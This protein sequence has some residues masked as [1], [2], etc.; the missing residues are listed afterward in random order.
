MPDVT[1]IPLAIEAS[2]PQAAERLL[3]RVYE[4]LRRLAA[5]KLAQ[6]QPGHTLQPTALVHEAYLR[7]MG[8]AAF[9]NHGHAVR[10][11]GRRESRDAGEAPRH[12]RAG[13]GEAER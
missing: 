11:E 3:P 7:L 12:P 8:S 4:E 2:D 1:P 13:A 10:S 5:Q 6:E 9:E